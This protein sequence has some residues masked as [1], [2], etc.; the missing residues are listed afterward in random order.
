M[1]VL[2]SH[3]SRNDP[4]AGLVC[5]AVKTRLPGLE[6]LIDMDGLRPGDEWRAILYH[7][8]AECHAAVV[9]LNREAMASSWVL[10]EVNILLW[11]RA[12]GYP[13]KI[14][15]AIL[16]D[17]SQ[18][19]L[20]DAGFGELTDLQMAKLGSSPR[21]QETAERIAE[22]V[23]AQLAGWP[24][25]EDN[26][27][28]A[29][30]AKAVSH[31]LSM[32]GDR[33]SLVAAA[34]QLQVEDA[35]LDRV[36][37][38]QEGPRFVAHQ[39]L[40][41]DQGRRIYLAIAEI[42]DY[43]PAEWLGRLIDKIGAAWVNGETARVLLAFGRGKPGTVVL[44][45]L[46]PETAEQYVDRA[47]CYAQTGYKCEVV[48]AV[49]G[50]SFVEEFEQECVKAVDKLLMR[51]PPFPLEG[52]LPPPD[53]LFLI[54]NPS[55]TRLELVAQG[56]D[57]VQRRFPWLVMVLLTGSALPADEDLVAWRLADAVKLE[58]VLEQWE[59]LNAQR[60]INELSGLR[61]R[62]WRP[63]QEEGAA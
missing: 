27:E 18:Q 28:M 19:D 40:A 17:F 52:Y 33:D 49:A 24:D 14:V 41:R 59:E 13:L 23:A 55:S 39:L 63:R 29:R 36:R 12:L 7:W 56:M 4:F 25:E 1:K 38:P 21:T 62:G 46:T 51:T 2:I 6:I 3:S 47:T 16:G 58:P 44:N 37:D 61:P 43:T 45:A 31:A 15:P 9:L 48:T 60:V 20:K 35:Y 30:W 42:A 26:S 53:V 10:R 8:L 57:V 22:E 5:D 54:V 50:E 32:V 34:R 11:R